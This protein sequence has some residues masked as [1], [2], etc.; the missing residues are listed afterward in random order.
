MI[1]RISF[2]NILNVIRI[3]G[4]SLLILT[5]AFLLSAC[6][7]GLT[8][9]TSVAGNGAEDDTVEITLADKISVSGSGVRVD[10]SKIAITAA[11]TYR[12]RGILD[13]GQIIVKAEDTESVKLILNGANISYSKG[14]PVYVYNAGN[15]AIILA[16]GTENYITDGDS[17][18]FADSTS[19]EPNAAI[20]SKDNLTIGGRGSLTVNANYYNGIQS[21]DD[22]IITGGTITVNAVNDGIKG[23]D[24][25]IIRNA[26]LTV[27]AGADGI[28]S[29]N[30]GNINKGYVSI[31]SSTLDIDAGEDGIQAAT[32]LAIGSGDITIFSGGGSDNNSKPVRTDWWNWGK[33][34]DTDNTAG[35]I[36][37]KALKAAVDITIT[38]GTINIDSSD[39]AIH[40]ND[41][42]T[43]SGG[44]ILLTSGD[45]GL[46]SDSAITING[47][48]I[49]IAKSYEGIDSANITI[50]GGNIHL[51][52]RDDGINAASGEGDDFAMMGW[53]GPDSEESG[54]NNLIITG[55]YI[56]V[57][58][59]G[60]GFDVNGPI[61]M[62]G[63]TVIIN[64]PT[65]FYN[66]ALD[67]AGDFRIT[68]GY[69]VAV[70][71]SGMPQAPSSSSTQYSVMV[72]LS[73]PQPANRMFHIESED[74]EG[75]LTF[76]PTKE[77]QSVVLCSSGLIN[78][79]TYF[80]Y[81]G[82][83]STGVVTDGLYSEGTYSAGTKVEVFT[84]SSMVTNA[85]LP[86]RGFFGA[87][88][89]TRR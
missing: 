18:I 47:G 59:A 86:V 26:N 64:G 88:G 1:I 22:L 72:N 76:V 60:D 17:Y 53:P 24:S 58:S 80:V 81:T 57:D 28:Q 77:Y 34:D 23:R 38:G 12:I 41:S 7:A 14:A 78:G 52:S 25:I 56:V 37:A 83:S 32:N 6:F 21:K 51:V 82:G 9:S 19:D 68:G 50:N 29:N 36:S 49:F 42:L 61:E 2:R 10:G 63:G 27:K 62:T 85:G 13:D 40:S 44:D 35:N 55:G 5:L 20:F 48:D 79:E 87:Q 66:G 75:I 74:C 16:D 71:S 84:I 33:K 4:L 73:S 54:D 11:G 89:G 46:H 31:E 70:G 39:D 45:D 30:T 3:I 67:Y 69:L 43:I 15:T 8:V 65:V